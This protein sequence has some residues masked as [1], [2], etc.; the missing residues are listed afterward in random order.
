MPVLKRMKNTYKEDGA[1][2]IKST[3]FGDDKD[4]VLIKS[5]KSF[6][7][8]APDVAYHVNKYGRGFDQLINV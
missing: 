1:F 3:L 5:D 2:W 7:Y 8:L 4:R 6:S